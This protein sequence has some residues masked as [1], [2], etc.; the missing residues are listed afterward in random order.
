MEITRHNT[1]LE[2]IKDYH[3]TISFPSSKFQPTQEPHALSLH[4][5]LQL[6]SS[7]SPIPTCHIITP[8]VAKGRKRRR[9]TTTPQK[10]LVWKRQ[11]QA[12]EEILDEEETSVSLSDILPL[13]WTSAMSFPKLTVL[14]T[15]PFKTRD[16]LSYPIPSPHP[17][18]PPPPPPASIGYTV[19]AEKYEKFGKAGLI[20][21]SGSWPDDLARNSVDETF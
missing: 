18:I 13:P 8:I 11:T 16:H 4:H 5:P 2:H 6:F 14:S 7:F 19:F 17:C 12:K 15:F 3:P 20:D 9:I 1:F 10:K 21:G